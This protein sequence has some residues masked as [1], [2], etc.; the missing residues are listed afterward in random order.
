VALTKTT[1]WIKKVAPNPAVSPDATR[2]IAGAS[3]SKGAVSG[4]KKTTA[5]SPKCRVPDACMLAEASLAESQ[6][7]LP[8]EPLP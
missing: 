3:G 4:A 6:E 5:T 7:S 8:H 1:K 2:V